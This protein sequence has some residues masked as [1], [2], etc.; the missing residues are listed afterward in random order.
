MSTAA[1][2]PNA[3]IYSDTGTVSATY[4]KD[5]NQIG[6]DPYVAVK[7]SS[8]E[9]NVFQQFQITDNYYDSRWEEM[10]VTQNNASTGNNLSLATIQGNTM[11]WT[12][13]DQMYLSIPVVQT[14]FV[15]YVINAGNNVTN[16]MS[17]ATTVGY[18]P[19]L[20]DVSPTARVLGG[21]QPDLAMMEIFNKIE[22][23]M[24]N[25]NQPIGRTQ[26]FFKEGMKANM[27]D[28]KFDNQIYYQM[29]MWGLFTPRLGGDTCDT[30]F[31]PAGNANYIFSGA[32][33]TPNPE[34]SLG[35]NLERIG[36][37]PMAMLAA[38][39][40]TLMSCSPSRGTVFTPSTIALAANTNLSFIQNQVVLSLP[41]K[42]INNF[43]RHKQFLPPDFKFKFNIE[44]YADTVGSI[45]PGAGQFATINTNVPLIIKSDDSVLPGIS[46][47]D[48]RSL[49][50]SQVAG[51]VGA[52]TL[53]SPAFQIHAGINFAGIKLIY[54]NNTLRQPLQQQL[55]ERWI[56]YPFVYNYETFETYDV[57]NSGQNSGTQITRDIAISQQRPTELVFNI[58]DT[59]TDS[60]S[61]AAAIGGFRWTKI[62]NANVA[63]Y[64][65][66]SRIYGASQISSVAT[67]VQGS[68]APKF[69]V[70]LTGGAGGCQLNGQVN[71]PV[72]TNQ[73]PQIS[74]ISIILGGRTQYYYRND[75]NATGTANFIPN[76]YDVMIMDQVR[77]SYQDYS[78]VSTQKLPMD[79]KLMY[80]ISGQGS[81][82]SIIIA[83]GG[84]ANTAQVPSD[85]G[86]T[87]IRV[88]I[89]LTSP[90]GSVKKVQIIK[91]T[92]ERMYNF[93]GNFFE[94]FC[95]NYDF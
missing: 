9:L 41:L 90:L 61:G 79:S 58:I 71:D 92:P 19:D 72:N 37:L 6:Q 54:Q 69:G 81:H 63:N 44:G 8:A 10:Y 26:S 13:A 88:Q 11:G 74:N 65:A 59:V 35:G 60:G 7:T 3:S 22:V 21:I 64:V 55:N 86:A 18:I 1:N 17:L 32:S 62:N 34:F 49:F 67:L 76:A 30:S 42:F 89:N 78:T 40:D 95:F 27:R 39:Y 84:Y 12:R 51:T 75:L 93:F 31:R 50:T 25:N 70:P 66:Q 87:V 94:I 80:P 68:L 82:F 23:Y 28:Y 52:S 48:A 33:N 73:G 53:L 45:T 2:I 4:I 16:W 38:W 5:L 36:K 57:D 91:K 14:Q 24:G 77:E 20:K 15:P 47:Y 83:P 46:P 43:F 56:Q 85:L 29:G